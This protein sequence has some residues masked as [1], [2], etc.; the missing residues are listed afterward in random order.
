MK[1]FYIILAAAAALFCSCEEWQPVFIGEYEEPSAYV[2]VEMTAT[3]TIQQIKD[4][5]NGKPV[6]ITDDIIIS[7]QI[8][9]SDATGNVYR[10]FYIQ[11]ETGGIEVKIGKTGLYNDY[12]LGQR[13]YIKCNGL[14]VGK[15]GGMLQLGIEVQSG[16]YETAYLDV[17]YII[18]KHIFKGALETPI[19]PTVIDEAGVKNAANYGKFV[20][21]NNLSY[22][23]QIFAI[24]YDSEDNSTYL[25]YKSYGVTTWAMSKNGFLNYLDNGSFQDAIS[26]SQVESFRAAASAYSVSQY[27]TFGNTDIQVRTS[28]Y[29]KFADH[30]IP[31]ELLDGSKKV[32]LIGILTIYNSN[33]Q[34]IILDDSEKSLI[35][36][37]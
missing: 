30:Q 23:N 3:H 36:H 31:A 34:F 35:I 33:Y 5:Y 20:R 19:E 27:F 4:M 29:S 37:D 8:T 13:I 15:D 16:S 17:Q 18:E 25:R 10:S 28:G 2:P 9:T 32:D 11:D 14:V 22:G 12:K 1:K 21:L 7:G 26:E 6:K 24:L